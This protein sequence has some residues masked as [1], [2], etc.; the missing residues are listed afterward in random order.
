MRTGS[1]ALTE[2]RNRLADFVA[3]TKPRLNSLVV[4]T[5]G[6]G[7]LAGRVAGFDPVVL[8]NTTIGAALVAGGAAALNQIA[9]RDLDGRMLRTQGR[10]IPAGRLHA[11][12]ATWLAVLFSITGLAQ[13]AFGANLT[14]AVV[15]LVT[16]VS[17]VG[18]YTPMK[19]WTHWAVL[20]GAVPGALP[21][22][23]GWAAAGPL[24]ANTWS[25]FALAFVWQLPHFLALTWLYRVDFEKA[26][27]P[28]LSVTDPS[29]LRTARHLL[30]YTVLLIPVSLTPAWL[31][32]AGPGYATGAGV[33]GAGLL[34]VATRFAARRSTD[35]ARLLFRATLLYLPLIWG[36]LL[37]D[38]AGGR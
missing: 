36:L 14:A 3:L 1:L 27:L 20:V 17:Y 19:R 35:R 12:E 11:I 26:G 22:V 4:V 21:V 15:A 2:P 9:E 31:G 6:V 5:T 30:V 38:S 28:L 25:L 18:I 29:G 37:V 24:S 16:L 34:A 33:L 13:L 10:P 8:A 7:Y 32:L 23:I